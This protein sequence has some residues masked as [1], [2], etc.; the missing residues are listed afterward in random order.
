[1]LNHQK[2]KKMKNCYVVVTTNRK[3]NVIG[4]TKTFTT[5]EKALD[6]MRFQHIHKVIALQNLYEN[7]TWELN[8][9]FATVSVN[10]KIA[11]RWDICED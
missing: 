3:G 4:E 10:G 2:R 6:E 7:V 11:E 1:M 9:D 5:L 8:D